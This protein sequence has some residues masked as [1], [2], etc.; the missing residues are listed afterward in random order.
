MAP[1]NKKLHTPVCT[2]EFQMA[3]KNNGV[4]HRNSKWPP[5]TTEFHAG[6]PTSPQKLS[7]PH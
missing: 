7:S 5:K 4:A 3:P 6:I 1:K 2:P